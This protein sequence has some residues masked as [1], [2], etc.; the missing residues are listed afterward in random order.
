MNGELLTKK[1]ESMG[2]RLKVDAQPSRQP[3]G[4][5]WRRRG[6]LAIDVQ[7][8]RRGEYFSIGIDATQSVVDVVEVRRDIRHLLVLARMG[9]EG[10]KEKFLCGHDERAWF[11]A[12]VPNER[13]VSNVRTATEALKP[14]IVRDAQDRK[15]VRFRHRGKRGTSAYVRQGEWFFVPRPEFAP[16]GPVLRNEPIRRGTRGKP[17]VCEALTRSGGE[18][19]YVCSRHPTGLVVERYRSLIN[20]TP[21]AKFWNWQVMQ[22]DAGVYVSG[23]VRHPD[24][25]TIGLGGWHQ[26]AMNTESRAPAMRH[27]AFLD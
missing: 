14:D 10:T 12:A 3:P 24:H 6:A 18:T 15:R 21:R 27:V 1:F 26:L 22:R 19:V 9:A 25:K 20:R 4:G 8:D 2:A 13:G 11:V 7:R 17:H 5:G 16:V 23:A